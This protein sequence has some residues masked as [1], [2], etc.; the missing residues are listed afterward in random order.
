[1]PPW[2]T[3]AFIGDAT[4]RPPGNSSVPM[5]LSTGRKSTGGKEDNDVIGDAFLRVL[6][7]SCPFS[8]YF[9]FPL[10]VPSCFLN[11]FDLM[12]RERTHFYDEERRETDYVRAI[13]NLA[14]R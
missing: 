1:M 4:V 10:T 13:L 11:P 6:L 14:R 2:S 9:F 7:S 12:Q 3:L 8:P 5:K